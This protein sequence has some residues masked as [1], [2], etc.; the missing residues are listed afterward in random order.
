MKKYLTVILIIFALLTF[1]QVTGA[2][3]IDEA[4]GTEVEVW[5]GGQS[6]GGIYFQFLGDSR[7][8]LL[9]NPDTQAT[10][11]RNVSRFNL[12]SLD[13]LHFNALGGGSTITYYYAG[14]LLTNP[15]IDLG[16]EAARHSHVLELFLRTY[17]SFDMPIL[18]DIDSGTNMVISTGIGLTF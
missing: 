9:F 2:M 16:F 4:L 1:T 7:T 5:S 12:A 13:D 3:D 15:N 10:L 17:V 18:G 14:E 8:S 11:L 6:F